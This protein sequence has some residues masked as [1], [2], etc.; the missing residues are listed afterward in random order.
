LISSQ[1]NQR[2]PPNPQKGHKNSQ[3]FYSQWDKSLLRCFKLYNNNDKDV[4]MI[5]SVKIL[6]I[7]RDIFVN[8]APISNIINL[9]R[10]RLQL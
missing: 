2:P 10:L 8:N 5:G 9:N 7:L 3:Y 6:L 4:H 1:A